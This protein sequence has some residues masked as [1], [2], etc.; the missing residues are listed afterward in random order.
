MVVLVAV[1]CVVVPPKGRVESY[2]LMSYKCAVPI[3]TLTNGTRHSDA[4]VF[5]LNGGRK[6]VNKVT[7]GAVVF[8]ISTSPAVGFLRIIVKII[9][10]YQ[11]WAVPF[12]CPLSAVVSI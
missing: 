6:V 10:K 4:R 11:L 1:R 7:I 3:W 9:P 8:N 12:A 2:I 5:Q